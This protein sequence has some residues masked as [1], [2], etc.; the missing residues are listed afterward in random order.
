MNAVSILKSMKLELKSLKTHH[1]NYYV[2]KFLNEN[3]DNQE[4][5][6]LGINLYINYEVK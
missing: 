3:D 2:L 4:C 6:E 1:K 5:Q